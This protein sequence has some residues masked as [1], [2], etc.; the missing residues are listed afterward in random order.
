MTLFCSICNN[1]LSMIS[2]ADN[3]YFTCNKC[4]EK[5]KY[6]DEDSMIYEDGKDNELLI[7]NTIL[8]TASDDPVNPKVYR[9][10]TKCNKN[11]VKQVRI[12]ENMRLINT[13]VNCK[14]QWVE[15][16]S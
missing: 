6:S 2:T 8:Q 14:Y 1:I 10:C 7:Y 16:L 3:L 5:Y 15:G 9:D 13:C 11:I 12:G 4:Q